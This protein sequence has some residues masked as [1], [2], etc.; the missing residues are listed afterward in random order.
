MSDNQVAAMMQADDAYAGSQSFY[1]LLK[2]VQDVL[3]KQYYLPVH[4]GRA[5]ENIISNAY[6]KNGSIIPMTYHFTPAMAPTTQYGGKIA[7]LLYA[8]AYKVDSSHPFKGNMNLEKLEE[9]IQIHGAKNIPFIRMEAS[10]NLIGGQPF[11][12]QNLRDVRAIADKYKDSTVLM[13][14]YW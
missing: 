3:G 14:A 8:E 9:I 10:T 12:V 7:E 4:Q 5:A 1:R 6:V 13:P 11:S 2:A